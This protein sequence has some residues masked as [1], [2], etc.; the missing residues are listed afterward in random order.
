MDPRNIE[1]TLE[2]VL[3]AHQDWITQLY[4]EQ[5]KTALEIVG[6]LHEH[7]ISVTCDHLS[8]TRLATQ[9]TELRLPQIQ[10]V[11]REWDLVQPPSVEITV[12]SPSPTLSD[13]LEFV[14][15][16]PSNDTL[17]PSSYTPSDPAQIVKYIQRPL[18][19]LPP[20]NHYPNAS[21]IQKRRASTATDRLGVTCFHGPSASDSHDT[22]TSLEMIL[23]AP[24]PL[25]TYVDDKQA[26]ERIAL[27]LEEEEVDCRE[28][29]QNY[30][31]AASGH[32]R[33]RPNRH[34]MIRGTKKRKKPQFKEKEQKGEVR[35]RT[36]SSPCDG[37]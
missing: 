37:V 10:R 21:K 30:R 33:S 13:D 32:D 29:T 3:N 19:S 11:L 36:P 26:H 28:L 18:P 20:T 25:E 31:R 23:E 35:T 27:G 14:A 17:D 34:R 4:V 7:G 2:D 24:S 1:L 6:R 12:D 22:Q 5:S 8:I 9:L 16:A 15:P